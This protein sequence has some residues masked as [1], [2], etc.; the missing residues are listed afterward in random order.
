MRHFHGHGAEA[1]H[2]DEDEDPTA[3]AAG[4]VARAE[5][6]TGDQEASF[7]FRRGSRTFAAAFFRTTTT[8]AAHCD[9]SSGRARFR[10]VLILV[11]LLHT[12]AAYMGAE[13]DT[14]LGVP[15]IPVAIFSVGV[16]GT[17]HGGPKAA[18]AVDLAH[19]ELDS[20]DAADSG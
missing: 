7:S 20:A 2:A 1:S 10:S 5:L 19:A 15:S 12:A 17:V 8:A 13:Q 16:V 14:S 11:D 3:G 9:R 6:A 4:A 18:A